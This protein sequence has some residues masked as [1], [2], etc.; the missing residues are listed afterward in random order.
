MSHDFTDEQIEGL[1]SIPEV[2]PANPIQ[3]MQAELDEPVS[4]KAQK[5][6]Y[7]VEKGD[8][9]DKY[10]IYWLVRKGCMYFT[11]DGQADFTVRGAIALEVYMST[12]KQYAR[13]TPKSKRR[14]T[15]VGAR[16]DRKRHS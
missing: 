1:K 12:R 16:K 4:Y 5:L 8:L 7:H 3:E 14:P 6:M 15:G 9:R 13:S 2:T 10:K 11:P